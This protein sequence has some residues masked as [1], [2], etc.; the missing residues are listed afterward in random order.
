[1]DISNRF[2]FSGS[3]LNSRELTQLFNPVV[4]TQYVN[5]MVFT[6][7]VNTQAS[8][9]RAIEALR[10]PTAPVDVQNTRRSGD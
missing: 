5:N 7:P 9:L 4:Q 1:M 6:A 3:A 8:L 10:A 2:Q